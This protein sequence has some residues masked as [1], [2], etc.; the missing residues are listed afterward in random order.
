[1]GKELSEAAKIARREYKRKWNAE[2]PEKQKEYE[3][4]FWERKAA[5]QASE[6]RKEDNNVGLF[7]TIP[8]DNKAVEAI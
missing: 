8:G 1:M 7:A 3:K 4:R 5:E 6:Q 2:H